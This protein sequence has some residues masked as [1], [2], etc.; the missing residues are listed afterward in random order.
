MLLIPLTVVGVF[1]YL[2]ASKGVTSEGYSKSKYLAKLMGDMVEGVLR[3]ELQGIITVAQF[4][5]VLK[6]GRDGGPGDQG[7]QRR[8]E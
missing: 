6:N 3:A 7:K 2:Q 4:D 8:H 5:S 1:S